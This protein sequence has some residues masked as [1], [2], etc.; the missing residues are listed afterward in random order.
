MAIDELRK[1]YDFK[2]DS[3]REPVKEV[4]KYMCQ[5]EGKNSRLERDRLCIFPIVAGTIPASMVEFRV[6]EYSFLYAFKT[7][8]RIVK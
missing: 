1:Y 5:T 2:R 3:W 4:L 7:I 6:T 8:L